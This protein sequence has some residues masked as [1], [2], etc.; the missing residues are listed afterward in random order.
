M[1]GRCRGCCWSVDGVSRRWLVGR[2]SVGASRV[3][4]VGRPSGASGADGEVELVPPAGFWDRPRE[5][6]SL[7]S[8]DPIRRV[9][10][11]GSGPDAEEAPSTSM[12]GEF[13]TVEKVAAD[14]SQWISM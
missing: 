1:V 11:S 9:A 5:P 13:L 14:P 3:V 12:A 10:P 8:V 7:S 4:I 2:G 6:R